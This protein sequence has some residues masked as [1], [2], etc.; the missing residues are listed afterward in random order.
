MPGVVAQVSQHLLVGR[1]HLGAGGV[2]EI[3]KRH[4]DL[5]GVGV[6]VGPDAAVRGALVPLPTDVVALLDEDRRKAVF[7]QGFGGD[8]ARRPAPDDGDFRCAHEY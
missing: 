3:R 5:A 7:Q 1:K 8:N 2:V 6:H 4:E